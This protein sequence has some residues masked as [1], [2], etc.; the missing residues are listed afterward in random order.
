MK[1]S[2]KEQFEQLEHIPAADRAPSGSPAVFT[3]RLAQPPGGGLPDT[4]PAMRAL[5]RRGMDLLMAKRAIEALL[6]NAEVVVN[7]PMVEDPK[8]LAA[9]LAEAGIT[10]ESL[11]AEPAK[12]HARHA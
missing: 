9:A 1:S 5:V 12:Y 2:L 7:L 3:L 10:A 6:Q 8:V 4:I 11:V